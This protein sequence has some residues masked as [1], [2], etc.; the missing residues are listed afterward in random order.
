MGELN[1]A[2]E[3]YRTF[4][5][6]ADPTDARIRTVKAGLKKLEGAAK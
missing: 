1:L 3:V 6:M 4:I 2:A 5:Q